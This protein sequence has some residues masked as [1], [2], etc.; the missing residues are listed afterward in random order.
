ML[1]PFGSWKPCVCAR[2]IWDIRPQES[3]K[4]VVILHLGLRSHVAYLERP[5]PT[6]SAG[7]HLVTTSD[8]SNHAY[9]VCEDQ[10]PGLS[11]LKLMPDS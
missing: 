8:K 6:I 7:P 5:S 2:N 3:H 9:L 10:R 11:C 4:T 1:L